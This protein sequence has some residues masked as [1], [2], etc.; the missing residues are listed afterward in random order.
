MQLTKTMA[1]PAFSTYGRAQ[2]AACPGAIDSEAFVSSSVK[3]WASKPIAVITWVTIALI[4]MLWCHGRNT[5]SGPIRNDR[6]TQLLKFIIDSASV[7][8]IYE[9]LPEHAEAIQ[10]V[11]T[12]LFAEVGVALVDVALVSDGEPVVLVTGGTATTPDP[13]AEASVADAM[14]Q[15]YLERSAG[16]EAGHPLECKPSIAL[17]GI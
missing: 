6:S 8:K 9:L 3:D 7:S 12:A 4:P 15:Y 5:N 10:V 1:P 14:T 13:V 17:S 11:L 16:A 2:C